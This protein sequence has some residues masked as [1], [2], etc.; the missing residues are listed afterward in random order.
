[1]MAG[2][3]YT[4]ELCGQ[5]GLSDSDMRSH[6]LLQHV[7]GGPACPVCDLGK[8]PFPVQLSCIIFSF[9]AA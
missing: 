4:C 9:Q 5:A 7:E 8:Q 2:R 3:S 1:M 6:M